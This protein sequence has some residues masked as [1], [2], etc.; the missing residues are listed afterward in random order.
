MVVANSRNSTW[1]PASITLSRSLIAGTRETSGLVEAHPE[2]AEV[3]GTDQGS[4][5]AP[6]QWGSERALEPW[7]TELAREPWD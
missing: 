2:R 4:A 1:P 6:E 5:L 3:P 7:E